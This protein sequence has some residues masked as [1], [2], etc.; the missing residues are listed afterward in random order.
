[1]GKGERRD[2]EKGKSL[3]DENRED[4]KGRREMEEGIELGIK[5]SKTVGREGRQ[6]K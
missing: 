3:R 5:E 4:K 1:M 2:Q 6:G